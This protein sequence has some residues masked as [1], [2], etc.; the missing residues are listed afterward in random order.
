MVN[1]VVI[2]MGQKKVITINDVQS[3]I[4]ESNNLFAT[5]IDVKGKTVEAMLFASSWN[6]GVYILTIE[7][8]TETS[9][10]DLTPS[11]SITTEQLIELQDANIIDGGQTKN[12][13][14]LKANGDVPTM[15]IPICICLRG[16]VK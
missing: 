6:N 7:G 4:D 1:R 16:E 2:R 5:N 10:Q 3:L 8:V 14:I 13:I 15:D 12:A 9:V 11:S